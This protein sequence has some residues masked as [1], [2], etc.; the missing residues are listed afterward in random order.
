MAIGPVELLVVK[1]PGNQFKGEIAPAL[2]ELVESGTIRVIDILFVNKDA[3]GTVV[4]VDIN[5]LDDD[6]FSQFDPIVQDVT[7]MLTEDDVQYFG[8]TLA[9]NSSMAMMLF[10][11]TW[12]TKFRDAVLNAKGELVLSER[13]PKQ[14]IDEMMADKKAATA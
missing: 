6:D 12:A 7:G 4:M 3:D 10:E 8:A 14:V 11:N 5:D 1:F 9:P 13:I 2:Q